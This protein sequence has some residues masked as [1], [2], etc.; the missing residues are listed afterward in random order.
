MLIYF[1]RFIQITAFLVFSFTLTIIQWIPSKT[2][3]NI[4]NTS[5]IILFIV[6][7][8][9]VYKTI[10]FAYDKQVKKALWKIILYTVLLLSYIG[11][12]AILMIGVASAKSTYIASYTFDDKLFY[13]YKS[14][15]SFYEISLKDPVLPIRSLPIASFNDTLVILKKDKKYIYALGQKINERI[16]NLQT[17]MKEKND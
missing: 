16:Y 9:F 8:F 10:R 5:I 17:N 4:V 14:V 2:L 11:A 12:F 13:V 1:K 6:A 7:V 3:E 15:D